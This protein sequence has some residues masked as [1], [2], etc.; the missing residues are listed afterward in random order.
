MDDILQ[1]FN[2][3]HSNIEF[4]VDRFEN[5]VPH[6]LDLELHQDGISIYRK[7][8]HTAQFVHHDSFTKW[9]HKIAWI[10]SLASRAK[11]L[12]SPGK[13]SAELKNI[14]RFASC[15]GFP[16]WVTKL[17]IRQSL[18]P[19]TTTPQDEDENSTDLYMF[20][21]Y[22]GKEAESIVFRCKKRLMKLFKRDIKVVFKV[23]FQAT[24]LAFFTSNKDKTSLLSCSGL[25]YSYSCP[26]CAKS[27]IGKT[28]NTLFNRT[29][30]HGWSDK[31]SA[32]GKHFRSCQQWKDIVGMF[33]IEDEGVDHRAFQINTV[34]NCTKILKRSDNWLKLAFLESLA[35]KEHSPELNSGIR[36]CKDL[37]LFG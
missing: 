22:S 9:A 27:Y 28:D 24:K 11:R 13:L 32:I 19:A 33:G 8:T 6:F 20:L 29:K 35:I 30:Q 34:R 18:R 7:D 25:V 12:C 23:H 2:S 21:P 16:R 4:T 31:D 10:R 1:Q 26:G 3:F 17:V 15:N 5:C 37:S 36:S 14:R